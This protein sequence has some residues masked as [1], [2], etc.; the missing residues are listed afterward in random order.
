V[1][2]GFSI[3]EITDAPYDDWQNLPDGEQAANIGQQVQQDAVDDDQSAVQR[4]LN[5]FRINYN[6][7]AGEEQV[8]S[9]FIQNMINYF[10]MIAGLVATVVLI[11]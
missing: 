10:L 3:D 2:Y 4:I 7:T 9:Y 6:E 11:I 1:S 8:A 5:A